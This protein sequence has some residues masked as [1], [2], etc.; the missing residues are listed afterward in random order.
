[1]TAATGYDDP[2]PF[3]RTSHQGDSNHHN[4]GAAAL[5]A[6]APSK[7]QGNAV[8]R[9][10]TGGSTST[11]TIMNGNGDRSSTGGAASYFGSVEHIE[12]MIDRL[13]NIG[14]Q[15]LQSAGG[16]AGYDGGSVAAASA[17]LAANSKSVDRTPLSEPEVRFLVMET[18]EIFMS[19]PML[20]ELDA[21]V[22]L[23]GDVHGQYTDLIR[24]FDLC[25]S[26]PESN[27]CFLGDYVDRG[28]HSLETICLLMAYKVRF[29]SNFFLLRGNHECSSINR[30]YG[31]F[32]ECKRRYSVRIWKL[33]TDTFNCMPVAGLIE[34]RILC[35]H[36]GISPELHNLEQIH[37]ILRPTDVPDSGL[38][39]D[40]LWADPDE[41]RVGWG[42]NDRGV[43]WTFG[44]DV[45]ERFCRQHD[46]DMICRAHQVVE[47]GYQFFSARRLVTVFSAPNYCGEFDNSAAVLNVDADLVCSFVQIRP[48]HPG[49]RR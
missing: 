17:R 10:A 38:I 48:L 2:Q 46:L 9:H 16:G 36:G 40:L 45:V 7:S 41:G 31:F 4:A 26:P 19:Q 43:S 47:E 32:D 33:F 25:G 18:R 42:Q 22:R 12:G 34:E 6:V 1:M 35:M 39:C 27:F 14:R 44:P 3:Y 23:C 28:K 21:P 8:T 5:A 11:T 13:R 15:L 24:L 49:G 37:K 30:I 29:P 20:V